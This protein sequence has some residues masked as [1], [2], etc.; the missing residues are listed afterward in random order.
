MCIVLLFS[1]AKLQCEEQDNDLTP[2]QYTTIL[3]QTTSNS[4]SMS[5]I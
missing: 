4:T 2:S 1:V 5:N 3:H